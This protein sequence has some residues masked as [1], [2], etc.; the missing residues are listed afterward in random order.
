MNMLPWV[1]L[2]IKR[3]EM[4]EHSDGLDKEHIECDMCGIG[5]GIEY[6]ETD[7]DNHS[8]GYCPF[9]GH[10]LFPEL[11][12][13]EDFGMQTQEHAEFGTGGVE[14]IDEDE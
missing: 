3:K 12:M 6:N 10:E 2:N 9:C 14:W 7:T 4:S 8:P 11:D 13:E 1:A 5:C